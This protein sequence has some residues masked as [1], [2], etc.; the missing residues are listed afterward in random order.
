MWLYEYKQ[1]ST[2]EPKIYYS[3]EF[4][5]DMLELSDNRLWWDIANHNKTNED[6]LETH[7]CSLCLLYTSILNDH[8]H[9]NVCLCGRS[10]R[11]VCVDDTTANRRNYAHM[12]KTVDTMQK[13]IVWRVIGQDMDYFN[14]YIKNV[15]AW[16]KKAE[17]EAGLF[18]S[19]A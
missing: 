14:T 10:G 11:H 2:M 17:R 12:V 3:E 5:Q 13:L 4:R 6:V 15:P 16:L 1:N 7:V 18:N 19:K 9:T 8:Y